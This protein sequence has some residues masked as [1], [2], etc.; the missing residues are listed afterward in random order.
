MARKQ[1]ATA[2]EYNRLGV[3]FFESGAVDLAL[4]QFRLATKRAPWV[5]SYWLNL[6]VALLEKNQQN[7]AESALEKAI[8]LDPRCQAAFYYLAQLYKRRGDKNAMR[9][10]YSKVIAMDP[11]TYLADR[12]REYLED[13]PFKVTLA[14]GGENESQ[15]NGSDSEF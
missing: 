11:H 13:R 15:E 3:T 6:G 2:G 10:A 7:E 8:K 5:S 4:E 12:A 14:I 9:D 1:R